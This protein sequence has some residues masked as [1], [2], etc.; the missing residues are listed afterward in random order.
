MAWLLI[1]GCG[2]I[3]ARLIVPWAVGGGSGVGEGGRGGGSVREV[4]VEGRG[5]V[6]GFRRGTEGMYWG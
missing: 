3:C 6:S 1:S 4:R 2:Y 5:A